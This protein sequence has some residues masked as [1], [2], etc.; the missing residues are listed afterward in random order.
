LNKRLH[1][2]YREA[3]CDA[4]HH[5]PETERE[6]IYSLAFSD[7]HL[8]RSELKRIGQEMKAGMVLR[9]PKEQEDALRP[10]ARMYLEKFGAAIVEGKKQAEAKRLREV[11]QTVDAPE[12]RDDRSGLCFHCFALKTLCVFPCQECGRRPKEEIEYV[13][14]IALSQ[15]FHDVPS[16]QRIESTTVRTERIF[17]WR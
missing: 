15:Q 10:G 14:S 8:D 9:I 5:V 7:H 17:A 1:R 3:A 13:H 4:C 2:V 16:L 6:L 12:E 11:S